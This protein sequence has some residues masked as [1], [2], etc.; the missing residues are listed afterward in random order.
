MTINYAYDWETS[1][2]E[3]HWTDDAACRDLDRDQFVV[4]N[5]VAAVEPSEANLAAMEVCARCPVRAECLDDANAARDS[6][7]IR[8]GLMPAAPERKTTEG[9]ATAAL[10]DDGMTTRDACHLLGVSHTALRKRIDEGPLSAHK[11]VVGKARLL[12]VHNV[13]RAKVPD[14][15]GLCED[16]MTTKAAAE[17]LGVSAKAVRRRASKGDIRSHMVVEQGVRMLCVHPA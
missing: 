10:C 15:A 13:E 16:G 9:A 7:T 11:V 1:T 2:P 17:V 12:C 6:Y 4:S 5:G 14:A 8:G 3:H